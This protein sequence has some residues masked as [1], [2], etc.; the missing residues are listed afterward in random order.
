[1]NLLERNDFID[2]IKG[3]SI[4]GV[5]II[6]IAGLTYSEEHLNL[7]ALYMDAFFRFGVPIFFGVLGYMT[8]IKY[9]NVDSWKVFYKRKAVQMLFPFLIWSSLYC[10]IPTVYPFLEEGKGKDSLLD[11][12]I[13]N[14][15]VHLYFMLPYLTFL[16]ITPLVVKL[17]KN[18]PPKT[19]S[20]GSIILICAHILLLMGADKSVI[21][22]ETNFY[23]SS[24]YM[25]II[26]WLSYYFI[27]VFIA[28]NKDVISTLVG[29]KKVT[30]KK[31]IGVTILYMIVAFVFIATLRI[32]M[33][34][35]T[36]LLVL[37]SLIAIWWLKVFYEK[38]KD[39]K[40]VYGLKK[41]GQR[42]LPFYL[43]HV[44]FIK[45]VFIWIFGQQISFLNLLGV[46]IIS[47]GLTVLYMKVESWFKKRW[48]HWEKYLN[49]ERSYI[50]F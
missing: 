2:F 5:F 23:N 36:P 21:Q 34:Y 30:W 39:L 41:L 1:M 35:S 11:I 50:K 3:F 42:T 37:N 17:Y 28:V 4:L 33:P 14:S 16:L 40:V 6:H 44:M 20:M 43:S 19:L 15:E 7:L 45:L 22:D 18:F 48:K 46:A 13:G 24:N 31:F 9:S 49:N 26:H 47:F 8:I 32:L 38:T 10:L 12:V 27:G 29:E 25:L